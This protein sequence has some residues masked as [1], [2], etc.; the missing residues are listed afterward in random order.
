MERNQKSFLSEYSAPKIELPDLLKCTTLRRANLQ[1]KILS[2]FQELKT[3]YDSLVQ[4]HEWNA[5]VETFEC[6]M[7]TVVGQTYYLY[8]DGERK[9]MSLI[10]PEDFT[11]KYEFKGAVRVHS[12]GYFEKVETK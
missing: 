5:Y 1:K 11:I 3:E 10:A 8:Q 2:K 4:L 6:R 7:E 12:D 9:F